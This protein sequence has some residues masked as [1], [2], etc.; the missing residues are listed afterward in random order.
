MALPPAFMDELRARTPISAVIGRRVRLARSGRNWKGCCPFHGEKTPSFYVY[1]DH[2]HCFG[3][4]AHGDAIGF[5]MQSQGSAFM[6]A[7]EQL[8]SEAGLS[9]P[10]PTPEAAQAERHRLDLNAVLEAAAA[11]YQRRLHLP[12]GR[13]ALSYLQTRGLTDETIDRFGLGWSG[14]GRGALAADLGR[15][16]VTQDQLVEAGLMRRDEDSGRVTDLFYNRV[17][18]PIRTLEAQFVA[19]LRNAARD[20]RTRVLGINEGVLANRFRNGAVTA[21]GAVLAVE[22]CLRCHG[23]VALAGHPLELLLDLLGGVG[24]ALHVDLV[25]VRIRLNTKHLGHSLDARILRLAA[26]DGF[27]LRFLALFALGSDL[28]TLGFVVR[29]K[30]S[31]QLRQHRVVERLAFEFGQIH[32]G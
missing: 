20:Q 30:C 17:M 14:E 31:S 1:D 11:A 26:G 21:L 12:E 25:Q 29:G 7:V 23:L 6:E 24:H 27:V 19:F 16:G 13:S 28:R 4:G 5:V 9:V 8:A 22:F 15:E 2:F 18:F 3:C 32:L 10:K